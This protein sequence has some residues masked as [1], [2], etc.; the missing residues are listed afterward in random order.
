MEIFKIR[1]LYQKLVFLYKIK[2]ELWIVSNFQIKA[3][4]N[5]S[6]PALDL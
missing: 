5:K 3:L 4:N 2:I 6:K 1:K